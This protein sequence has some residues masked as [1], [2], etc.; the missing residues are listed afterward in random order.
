MGYK[1]L[2]GLRPGCRTSGSTANG[3]RAPGAAAGRIV[4]RCAR[5]KGSGWCDCGPRPGRRCGSSPPGKQLRSGR[6][7]GGDQGEGSGLF[8]RDARLLVGCSCGPAR[9]AIIVVRR[10][11]SGVP[12]RRVPQEVLLDN[13]RS[14]SSTATATPLQRAPERSR[15]IGKAARLRALSA[16]TEGRARVGYVRGNAIAGHVFMTAL[17]AHLGG[18]GDRRSARARLYRR[19]ATRALRAQPAP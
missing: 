19:A 5:W 9:A 3:C 8:R 15:A 11:R 10:A 16:R 1:R 17:E 6:D 2:D 13:A 14:W 7:A 18:A 12:A 4:S